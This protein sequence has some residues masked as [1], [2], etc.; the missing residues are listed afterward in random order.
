MLEII[1]TN[2]NIDFM[3]QRSTW[4][5]VSCGLI[6]ITFLLLFTKNLNFGIDFSGGAV[7][8]FQFKEP[9]QTRDVRKWLNDGNIRF[10]ILQSIGNAGENEFQLKL[11]GNADNLQKISTQIETVFTKSVGAGMFTI[12][13]VDVVGP[14]AGKALRTASLWA[15][16]YAIIGILI[17]IIIRFD[18][19]Y[20]PGAIIALAHDSILIMGVFLVTQQEFSL[21]IVAAV[22][23][24]IGYSINDTIIVYDRIRET[25]K[26]NPKQDLEVNINEGL[27]RTLSRTIITSLTTLLSVSALWIFAGG[28]IRDFAE[29]LFIGVI[30]GT[31]SSIFIASPV[32]LFM[33]RRE[34]RIA[35]AHKMA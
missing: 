11:D 28:I 20:S 1:P 26:A 12:R 24:I 29:A 8:Q 19:R 10:S 5:A 3:G 35:Q 34:E 14:R 17:Y 16:I 2:T 4:L 18:F 13:K 31:Y 7:V 23:T 25:I 30:V 32:F 33:A 21:Q 9:T 6:L 22:L 15:A 27:N